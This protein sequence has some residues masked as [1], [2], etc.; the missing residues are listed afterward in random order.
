MFRMDSAQPDMLPVSSPSDL[1]GGFAH[2]SRLVLEKVLAVEHAPDA[3]KRMRSLRASE[4]AEIFGVTDTHLRR[5]ARE[6]KIPEGQIVGGNNRRTFSQ[7]DIG[8]IRAYFS[9]INPDRYDRH[10]RPED[11]MQVISCVNFKGGAAKTTT[12]VH[13]AQYLA[14]HGYRVLL[15]DLDSQGSATSAFG[16]IPDVEYTGEDTLYPFFTGERNSLEYAIRPTY[17]NGLDLIPACLELYSAEFFLPQRQNQDPGFDFFN[18][19]RSGFKTVDDRYDIVICDC[20]PSLGY[21]SINA[22]WAATGLII[23]IPPAMLDFASSGQ[24]FSMLEEIFSHL[25]NRMGGT[26]SFDFIRL[27]ITKADNS[28]TAKRI[29]QWMRMVYGESVMHS[30]MINTQVLSRAALSMRTAYEIERGELNS[31]TLVRGLDALNAVNSEIESVICSSWPS[32]YSE[33]HKEG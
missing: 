16:H 6:G 3:K 22:I 23:P 1:L 15:V 5:L 25:N 8:Q 19:L 10:R 18:L 2:K 9:S 20:P 30:P 27:L 24:F 26:H 32:R 7:E 21:L 31:Q 12:A 14:L 28:P 11:H 13:L 17:W 4:V 33:Q 29:S